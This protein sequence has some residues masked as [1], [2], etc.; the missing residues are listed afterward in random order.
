[1]PTGSIY[2]ACYDVIMKHPGP[3][4]L[5]AL[6][7]LLLSFFSLAGCAPK[8]WCTAKCNQIKL[9]KQTK[10][11]LVSLSLTDYPLTSI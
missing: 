3:L 1:M 9:K 4:V 5:K 10:L 7:F 8:M 6:G 2:K 11:E